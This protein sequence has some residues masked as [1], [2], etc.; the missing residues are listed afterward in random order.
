MKKFT[1]VIL[2]IAVVAGMSA[3][4]PS[5]ASTAGAPTQAATP[6][7]LPSPTGQPTEAPATEPTAEPTTTP[8]PTPTP[9][10]TASCPE[11]F[12]MTSESIGPICLGMTE[13][14]VLAALGHPDEE[15]EA[16]LWGADDMMHS[17]WEYK[18]LGFSINMS[19]SAN[20]GSE[21]TVFSINAAAPCTEATRRG[22]R[23]GDAKDAVTATYA[24]AV[25]P[26]ESSGNKVVV[27]SIYGGLIFYFKNG[28]VSTIFIGADAE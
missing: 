1:I 18:A 6:S 24:D 2:V 5:A 23:V 9:L 16:Q 7:P 26:E 17:D 20:P 4:S 11:D 19:D 8:E 22:I 21:F 28:A 27:G 15:S 25:N 14:E 10:R 3:C 12:D 13:S